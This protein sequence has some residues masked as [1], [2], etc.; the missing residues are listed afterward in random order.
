M[1]NS[2]EKVPQVSFN[3]RRLGSLFDIKHH[4]L[5][6]GVSFSSLQQFQI[7]IKIS[8]FFRPKDCRIGVG[9]TYIEMNVANIKE[10]D[11]RSFDLT[12][13]YGLFR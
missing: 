11:R 12:T 4:G 3:K 7:V 5:T 1:L 8:L 10:S 6:R 9:I 2:E 13:P